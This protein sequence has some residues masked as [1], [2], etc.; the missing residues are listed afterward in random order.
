M[1]HS[2]FPV[3]FSGIGRVKNAGEQCALFSNN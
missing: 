1:S 2:F 3:Q